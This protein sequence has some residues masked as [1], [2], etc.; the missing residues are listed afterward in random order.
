MFLDRTCF[1]ARLI[2]FLHSLS[3]VDPLG[4]EE[5]FI[6]IFPSIGHSSTVND[7]IQ[8]GWNSVVEIIGSFVLLGASLNVM[9]KLLAEGALATIVWEIGVD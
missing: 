5:V 2:G 6:S 1:D 4:N 9:T 8:A 3:L 7:V